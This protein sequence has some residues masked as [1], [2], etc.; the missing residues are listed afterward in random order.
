MDGVEPARRP[1]DARG[2]R[3]LVEQAENLLVEL[4]HHPGAIHAERFGPTEDEKV[5]EQ[6][7]LDGGSG[8]SAE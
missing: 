2:G 5:D 3:T 8:R 7:W 6:L 1:G 4:G